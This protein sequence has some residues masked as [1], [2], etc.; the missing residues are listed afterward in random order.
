M[1]FEVKIMTQAMARSR[2]DCQGETL[3]LKNQFLANKVFSFLS[4]NRSLPIIKTAIII[5][6]SKN[7]ETISA[8]A[9]LEVRY[10]ADN[11]KPEEAFIVLEKTWTKDMCK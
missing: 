5:P 4:L 1:E 11:K 7:L 3:P 2:L 9:K 6:A 8:A 10:F